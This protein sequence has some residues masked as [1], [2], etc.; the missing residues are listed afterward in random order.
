MVNVVNAKVLALYI[1]ASIGIS[2]LNIPYMMHIYRQ[3]DMHRIIIIVIIA[4]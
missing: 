1:I 3:A 2:G 4:H